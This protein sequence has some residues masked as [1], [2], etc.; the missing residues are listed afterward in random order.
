M[1]W[2]LGPILYEE[3]SLWCGRASSV[4]KFSETINHAIISPSYFGHFDVIKLTL[5]PGEQV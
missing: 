2:G 4:V 5:I 3:N 1:G